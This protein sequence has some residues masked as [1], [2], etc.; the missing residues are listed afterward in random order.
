MTD[1]IGAHGDEGW[2]EREKARMRDDEHRIPDDLLPEGVGPAWW[3]PEILR[4]AAEASNRP[5]AYHGFEIK[6]W[7]VLHLLNELADARAERGALAIQLAHEWD[8]PRVPDAVLTRLRGDRTA[9]LITFHEDAVRAALRLPPAG[10]GG[11]IA[12]PTRR[13]MG[14]DAPDFGPTLGEERRC[15]ICGQPANVSVCDRCCE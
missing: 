10:E 5:L 6:P 4:L 13:E 15:M 7:I 11:F 1:A 14:V 12:Q 8:W 3:D 2:R 9:A